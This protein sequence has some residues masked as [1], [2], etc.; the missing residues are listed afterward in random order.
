[1][2][3]EDKI[4]NMLLQGYQPRSLVSEHGFKKSTVYKVYD[5]VRT[6]E[7]NIR[8]HEWT[9]E[10]IQINGQSQPR[11]M[12]GNMIRVSF[13]FKN[14][15][16]Q[17]F[18]VVN[19]G[20]QPEWMVQ[21]SRWICQSFKDLVKPSQSKFVSVSFEVPP[22]IS[23]GE[24]E[25]TFGAEGQ[26]IPVQNYGEQSLSTHWSNPIIL[27]VK[28][29]NKGMT[30]FLSHSIQ[31]EYQVRE[32]EKKLDVEGVKVLIGEDEER[33]GSFLPDK[34]KQMINSCNIFIAI[35]THSAVAS[36]WVMWEVDYAIQSNK[37]RILLK[38]QSVQ[39]NSDY[40]WTEFSSNDPADTIFTKIMT[41]INKVHS[42]SGSD[43]ISGLIGLGLL[44]LLVGAL[45]NR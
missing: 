25:L 6:F 12:P 21:E 20:V 10:N 43:A 2:G 11:V 17:D 18:Y 36:K 38:D 24:Y 33:P 45:S 26:Y 35:L 41:S 19:L 4:R 28:K 3:T 27:D 5:T 30:I 39:I 13:S 23:L 37:P 7:D 15:T 29:P 32:L 40:E 14:N 1:M 34:F 22:N 8:P 9:F 31:D 42:G 44:A 16:N